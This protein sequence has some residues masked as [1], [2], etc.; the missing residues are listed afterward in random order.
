M[1]D[2]WKGYRIV[3]TTTDYITHYNAEINEGDIWQKEFEV[4][5]GASVNLKI[6]EEIVGSHGLLDEGS[7]H[8]NHKYRV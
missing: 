7:I 4:V 6:D 5:V 3:G 8:Q 1:G 2:N